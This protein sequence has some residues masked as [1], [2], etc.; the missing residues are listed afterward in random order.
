MGAVSANRVIPATPDQVWEVLGGFNG[1]ADWLPLIAESVA[2]A[3]GRV[4]RL[5]TGDGAVITERMEHF[6]DKQREYS[7]SF[8]ESPFAVDGYY[9]TIR[10]H[11]VPGDP[12]SAEV[13]WSGRWHETGMS[14][15]EATELFTGIYEGG[16]EALHK[17]LTS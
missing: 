8:V 7:Y 13:H 1:L 9:A 12:N 16:L 14:E 4:R 17:A 10:V 11:D 6:S 15:S 2:E 3:G 5:T